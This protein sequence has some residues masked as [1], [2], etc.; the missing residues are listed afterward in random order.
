MPRLPGWPK[1][2]L[3]GL[4]AYPDVKAPAQP[5]MLLPAVLIFFKNYVCRQYAFAGDATQ[6]GI[7][8]FSWPYHAPFPGLISSFNGI[9]LTIEPNL[10]VLEIRNLQAAIRVICCGARPDI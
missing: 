6:R 10:D 2:A 7:I 1:G 5:I 4:R 8:F 3:F 9:G